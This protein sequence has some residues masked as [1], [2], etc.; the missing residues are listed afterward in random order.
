MCIND[1]TCGIAERRTRCAHFQG[2]VLTL[3]EQSHS[4]VLSLWLIQCFIWCGTT[5]IGWAEEE[6]KYPIAVVPIKLRSRNRGWNKSKGMEHEFLIS[7][8][9]VLSPKHWLEKAKL[10]TTPVPFCKTRFC[11]GCF[12]WRKPSISGFI[13]HKGIF[14]SPFGFLK[15]FVS[16]RKTEKYLKIELGL[17]FFPRFF[18]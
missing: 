9:S 7:W 17:I 10:L 13:Q 5:P 3:P 11:W 16:A 6:P 2:N 4:L 18:T 8:A 14:F 15:A 1:L 12:Y